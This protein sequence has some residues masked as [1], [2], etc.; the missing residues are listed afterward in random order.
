MKLNAVVLGGVN[1][2][3]AGELVDWAWSL[4]ITP[5]F[6]EL[7]P[8]GEAAKLSA[9]HFLDHARLQG[10]LGRQARAGTTR[11]TVQDHGPARYLRARADASA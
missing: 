4:G 10:L 8:L 3:D 6:I 11:R 9:E 1:E 2:A 5:R 7:M